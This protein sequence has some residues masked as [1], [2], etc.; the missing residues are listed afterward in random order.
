MEEAKSGKKRL[1]SEYKKKRQQLG[2]EFRQIYSIQICRR[3]SE[4]FKPGRYDMV[5]AY[6]PLGYE[7][8]VLPFIE[9]LWGKQVKT[10]FPKVF[11]EELFFYEVDDVSQLEEGAF[12][13]MEPVMGK[14]KIFSDW[15]KRILVLTPGL[16]FDRQ[17]NR[18]GYGKGFYDRFFEAVPEVYKVGIAFECQMAEQLKAENWDVKMD[19]VITEKRI[20][21]G[22]FRY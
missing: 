11:G 4:Y 16:A 13:I 7:A 14:T 22:E 6:Y 9:E 1:R 18:M 2:E 10:A 21:R 20:Y 5:F 12:H 15:T 19:A 3:L 17:G 8:S